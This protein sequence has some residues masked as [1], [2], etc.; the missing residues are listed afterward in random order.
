MCLELFELLG[1]YLLVGT[2]KISKYS[3]GGL[4]QEWHL[5]QGKSCLQ[6]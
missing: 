1:I 6:E 3:L 4:G 2:W 5:Q